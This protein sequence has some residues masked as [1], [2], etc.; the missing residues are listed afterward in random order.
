MMTFSE[1]LLLLRR[2]HKM[3]Q[4]QLACVIGIHESGLRKY[5]L[6][7]MQP[8]LPVII[9]LADYF[10]VSLDYLCGLSDARERR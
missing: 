8:T 2:E 9:A 6:G 4:A 5:E 1:R 7:S 3:T 10:Q